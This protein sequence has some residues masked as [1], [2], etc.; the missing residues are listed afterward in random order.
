MGIARQDNQMLSDAQLFEEITKRKTS[1]FSALYDR[2]S[3]RLYGLAL[4][5]LKVQTLAEDVLQ[6]LFLDVWQNAKK[7]DHTKGEPLAW[8]MILCRNRCIDKLRAKEKKA[9]RSGS[10]SEDAMQNIASNESKD[11][12]ET[13]HYNEVQRT[14]T[15]ALAQLP[16][17][18]RLVIEMAYFRGLSQ[19]EIAAELQIPLGTIKTRVRLGMQK[20]RSLIKKD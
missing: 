10:I 18:Q 1:A 12:L 2:H 15:S 8:L 13:V 4:K 17:D 14:V 7:F 6:D 5:M 16:A 19:S 20:L 9:R 11:P 3:P